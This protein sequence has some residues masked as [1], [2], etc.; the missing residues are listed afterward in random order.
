LPQVCY[1]FVATF[2]ATLM[3]LYNRDKGHDKLKMSD[4]TAMVVA[5]SQQ[6]GDKGHRK[7]VTNAR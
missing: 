1:A 2:V 6:T 7:C 5:N 4:V 3:R